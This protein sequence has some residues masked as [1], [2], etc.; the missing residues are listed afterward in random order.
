MT[1]AKGTAHSDWQILAFHVD[2]NSFL[3]V[4]SHVADNCHTPRL[5]SEDIDTVKTWIL[6]IVESRPG[7]FSN[8]VC[9]CPE[10]MCCL[11]DV[12]EENNVC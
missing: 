10:R 9:V 5:S 12:L 4:V 7:S 8:T 6:D 2:V 1:F 11:Y 3:D